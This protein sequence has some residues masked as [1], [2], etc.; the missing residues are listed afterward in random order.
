MNEWLTIDRWNE[1]QALTRPGIV[2]E[3]QNSQGQSMFTPCVVPLPAAPENWKSP[4]VKFRAVV[5]LKPQHSDPLPTPK[6]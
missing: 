5:Q 6:K 2:F 4:G 3:I 1:C